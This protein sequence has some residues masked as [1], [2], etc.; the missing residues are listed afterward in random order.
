MTACLPIS[1]L[2]SR[3]HCSSISSLICSPHPSSSSSCSSNIPDPSPVIDF[4]SQPRISARKP[5]RCSY[6][7][8]SHHLYIIFTIPAMVS[9]IIN[10]SIHPCLSI[11]SPIKD[12][13]PGR[14]SLLAKLH[15]H[16]DSFSLWQD[17]LIANWPEEFD[18]RPSCGWG[19]PPHTS[20]DSHDTASCPAHKTL[21]MKGR[22]IY[23]AGTA[24][25]K[26][27]GCS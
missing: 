3:S 17:L 15:L 19:L 24:W 2:L 13:L 25:A 9:S 5:D 12:I 14:L 8:A 4:P 16:T 18:E 1:Y 22:V 27:C 11:T 21:M 23:S 6:S 26:A 10:T 20:S 7:V